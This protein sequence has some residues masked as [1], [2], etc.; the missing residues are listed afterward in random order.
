M[1]SHD[2]FYISICLYVQMVI[3]VF[4]IFF[5]LN[6]LLCTLHQGVYIYKVDAKYNKY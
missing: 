6:M 1:R 2:K 5:T 4:Y 3:T